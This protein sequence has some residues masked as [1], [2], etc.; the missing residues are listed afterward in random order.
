ME[1]AAWMW[2]AKESLIVRVRESL[3]NRRKEGIRYNDL[4]GGMMEIKEATDDDICGALVAVVFGG[5]VSIAILIPWTIKYLHDYPIVR[6]AIQVPS[7]ESLRAHPL[8]YPLT[9]AVH[10]GGT[11]TALRSFPRSLTHV[12]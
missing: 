9:T 8:S 5:Y 11:D 4:L 6:D 7:S 10:T 2:Q 12:D 1:F 3:A